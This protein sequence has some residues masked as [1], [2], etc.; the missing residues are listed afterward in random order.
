MRVVWTEGGTPPNT[1]DWNIGL[2]ETKRTPRLRF[3]TQ[4]DSLNSRFRPLEDLYT[5]AIFAVDDDIQVRFE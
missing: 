4:P 3:D 1:N 5:H 2:V